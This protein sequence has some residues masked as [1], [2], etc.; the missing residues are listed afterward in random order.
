MVIVVS[1]G[2]QFF[3]YIHFMSELT[4]QASEIM[5]LVTSQSG[6]IHAG[7]INRNIII[8]FTFIY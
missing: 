7:P 1:D 4:I 6:E 2:Q 8:V 5:L 3:Q